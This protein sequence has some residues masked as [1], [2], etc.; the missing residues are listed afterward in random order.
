MY[1]L[2]VTNS[3]VRGEILRHLMREKG[4]LA[5]ELCNIIGLNVTNFSR[6]MANDYVIKYLPT[7]CNLLNITENDLNIMVNDIIKHFENEGVCIR[8]SY[9]KN[10]LYINVPSC[11]IQPVI[12]KYFKSLY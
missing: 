8:Q 9:T 7:L 10:C 11:N 6:L 5:K 12:K 1:S 3:Q 4:L 2:Y